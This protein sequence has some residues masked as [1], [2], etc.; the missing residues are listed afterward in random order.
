VSRNEKIS[1]YG[2]SNNGSKH[3]FHWIHYEKKIRIHLYYRLNHV[4]HVLFQLHINKLLAKSR[5][6]G[7]NKIMNSS[8]LTLNLV[9]MVGSKNTN[10]I[11]T[12]HGLVHVSLH[13]HRQERGNSNGIPYK[14][15]N[16][17]L[18]EI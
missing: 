15:R 13:Y 12:P 14:W 6:Y 1:T 18:K 2:S 10:F 5:S 16:C 7:N 4:S 9:F 8:F 17:S 3:F 11:Y